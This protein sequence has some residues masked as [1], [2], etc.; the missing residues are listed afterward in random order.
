VVGGRD[1]EPYR[2][3]I[4]A[5]PIASSRPSRLNGF[6]KLPSNRDSAVVELS[7]LVQAAPVACRPAECGSQKIPDAIP[8]HFGSG[9]S[10]AE[11]KDI[12]IV[13]LHSLTRRVVVVAES[14]A[15]ATHLIGRYRRAHAA[16]AEQ[17]TPLHIS[18]CYGPSERDCEVGIVIIGIVNH[19]SE[20][21]D[22]M[23]FFRQP[24][25]ELHFHHK[26]AMVRA[27]TYSHNLLFQIRFPPCGGQCQIVAAA[28]I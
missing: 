9:G 18:V 28:T 4:S 3:T 21:N 25:G 15:C 13:V 17:Y 8:S 12:H 26:T 16:T 5:T 20:I 14:R 11:T 6:L 10:P 22:L 27:Y 24:S 7:Y 23:P 1:G 19:V 2:R